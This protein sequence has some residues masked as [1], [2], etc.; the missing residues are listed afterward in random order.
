MRSA[1]IPSS[2]GGSSCTCDGGDARRGLTGRERGAPHGAFHEEVTMRSTLFRAALMVLGSLLVYCAQDLVHYPFVPGDDGGP[3]GDGPVG[4]VDAQ[5]GGDPCACPVPQPQVVFD[6]AAALTPDANNG[7]YCYTQ[8]FDIAAYRQVV[9]HVENW[10]LNNETVQVQ[11]GA[12]GFMQL[13]LSD[14]PIVVD[15]RLG[16]KLR[17]HVSCATNT[18][19]PRALTIV[20]FK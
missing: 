11:H 18:P 14:V 13:G 10:S 4:R 7:G 5:T 8:T 3:P 9:I 12:A 20:G 19:T 2:G 16:A 1:S 15:P 17:L 6:G